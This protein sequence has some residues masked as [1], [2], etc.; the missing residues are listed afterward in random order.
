[1]KNLIINIIYFDQAN[2]EVCNN[3]ENLI[4][5]S[6]RKLYKLNDAVNRRKFPIP[7]LHKHKSAK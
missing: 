3:K 2:C 5:G 1:M 4:S 7:G 6:G